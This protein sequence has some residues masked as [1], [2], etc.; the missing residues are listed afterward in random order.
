MKS[1]AADGLGLRRDDEERVHALDLAQV[2]VRDQRHLR[3]DLLQRAHQV[4]GRA[5]DQ[6]RA[7]VGRVLAVARDRPDQDVAERVDDDRDGEH[8]QPDR[9]AV[10]VAPVAAAEH[11]GVQ[12]EAGQQRGE[13]REEARDGHDQHVAVARCARAR[14]RARPRPPSAR[15]GSRG[16]SSRRR[17]RASASGP[18]AKAFG[19]GV[20]MIATFGFGRSA[21]AQRRSTMSCSSGASSRLTILA[22]GGA[23]GR[24]CRRCSTG[25]TRA[26]RRSR[27]SARAR[28]SGTGRGRPRRRRRAGRAAPSSASIRIVRP[29]SRP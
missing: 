9:R 16:R 17:R 25:R 28:R 15:G 21:I 20:S 13:H 2:L 22:P 29:A 4:L 18:V 27:A 14:G 10:V 11:A 1:S 26:R 23:R 19:T 7:A 3:R 12:A 24:A 8:D 5:G 6:R